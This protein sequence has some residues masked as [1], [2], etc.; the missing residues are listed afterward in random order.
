MHDAP[1]KKAPTSAIFLTFNTICN[2][3]ATPMVALTKAN[4]LSR[5]VYIKMLIATFSVAEV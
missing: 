1:D 4:L 5:S 3:A 2:S